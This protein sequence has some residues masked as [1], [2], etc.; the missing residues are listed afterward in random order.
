MLSTL[1]DVDT[2][3]AHGISVNG[4]F[5]EAQCLV[6]IPKKLSLSNC[7]PF[8]PHMLLEDMLMNVKSL[9]KL[10]LFLLEFK[11]QL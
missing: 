5:F 11:I 6:N 1:A 3:C 7:P 4:R 10:N 8:L 2:I 9:N